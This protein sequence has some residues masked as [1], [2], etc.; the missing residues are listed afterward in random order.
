MKLSIP[1][2]EAEE[3]PHL[4]RSP[5]LLLFYVLR[6]KVLLDSKHFNYFDLNDVLGDTEE[7]LSQEFRERLRRSLL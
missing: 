6:M 2:S 1:I 3:S 5:C 4:F 7:V